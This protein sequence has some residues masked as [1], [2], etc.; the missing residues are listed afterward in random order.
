MRVL[1]LIAVF[2]MQLV[3]VAPASAQNTQTAAPAEE[4]FTDSHL[5]AAQTVITLV[6]GDVTF[7]DILPRVAAN[8]R[9]VF[10]RTNPSLTR[11]IEDSVNDAA[12]SMVR[13]RLDL[14][15]T[16]QLVWA[17]RF[18]EEELNE[19]AVFFNGPLGSKYVELFPII[20]ALSLGAAKQWEQVLSADMVTETRVRLREKGHSL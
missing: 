12:L 5:K 15:R 8:T 10:T 7:D 11:E 18:T 13:R 14:S 16:L 9:L 20:S 19:L 1:A 4:N 3:I 2:A 17:R 6:G